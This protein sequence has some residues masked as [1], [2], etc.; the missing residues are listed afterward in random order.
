MVKR[1]RNLSDVPR[2]NSQIS[3]HTISLDREV[4]ST[5]SDM[6]SDGWNIISDYSGNTLSFVFFSKQQ[7]GGNAMVVCL[8]QNR[9]IKGSGIHVQHCG[10][11]TGKQ[12][13]IEEASKCSNGSSGTAKKR[14]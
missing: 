6:L 2:S 5:L 4:G 3:L 7:D 13:S 9:A 10:M 11:D 8:D 14:E 12:K 1:N